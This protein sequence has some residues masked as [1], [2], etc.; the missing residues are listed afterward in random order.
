MSPDL[1]KAKVLADMLPPKQKDSCSHSFGRVNYLSKL[2]QMTV[3]TCKPL[4]RLTPV[5]AVWT[6]KKD[7]IKKH[8]REPT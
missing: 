8:T 1:A 3:N 7:H 5:N 2:P 6:W 4:R